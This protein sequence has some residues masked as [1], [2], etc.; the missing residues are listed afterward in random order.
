MLLQVNKIGKQFANESLFNGVSFTLDEGHKVALV[1]KNGVGKSTLMKILAGVESP[2]T[3]SVLLSSGRSISYVPQEVDG[4]DSRTGVEYIQDGLDIK[5]HQ[6]L[7]VLNGLGVPQEIAKQK[8]TS[9]SGGQQ[10]KILLTRLLL[11]PADIFLFDEPTNNLDIPSLL[12]LEKYLVSLK[13]AMI[14]VSHDLVFLDTV[15]NRVFELKDENL[16]IERGKYSHYLERK[17]KEFDRQMKEHKIHKEEISRIERNIDALQQKGTKIINTIAPDKD[18]LAAG[19]KKDDAQKA[20]GKVKTLKK[21]LDIMKKAEKPFEEEVISLNIKAC[22]TDSDI[23]IDLDDVVAGYTDGVKVGPLSLHLG[24]GDRICLMGENGSG[25]STLLKT[26]VG[27]MDPLDGNVKRT[28]CIVIGDFM[29]HHQQVRGTMTAREYFISNVS[30][31]NERAMHTLK[32]T[33]FTDENI[34]QQVSNLSSGMRARLQ[35]AIFM[36]LGVNVLILDE[37]TNHLDIETVNA[38]TEMLKTY[39]GIVLLVSHNRWFLKKLDIQRY[40]NVEDGGVEHI[41]EFD[42]YVQRE[43]GRAEKMVSKIKRISFN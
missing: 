25:K 1:G 27:T 6:F 7:P 35:F 12:W 31:D 40:Y 34:N 8:L 23:E 2:D 11:T 9:M 22:N 10:T 26:I 43:K 4:D 42:K 21:R 15:T 5:E 36:A 14:V 32:R 18:K 13:K 24:L 38:L 17:Q 30:S 33:G 20:Q 19:R 16:T 28:E 41:K 37:P 29:Q 3:G 39:D